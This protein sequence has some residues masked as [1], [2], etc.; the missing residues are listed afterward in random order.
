MKKLV[1]YIENDEIICDI[2]DLG[3]IP[4]NYNEIKPYLKSA[5]KINHF[6]FDEV[7]QEYRNKILEIKLL[8]KTV[9]ELKHSRDMALF[10]QIELT[11]PPYY[12]KIENYNYKA[13]L[14]YFLR[15][16]RDFR[17]LHFNDFQ[18][19]G[20]S[21]FN[22]DTLKTYFPNNKIIINTKLDSLLH[23]I[24]IKHFNTATDIIENILYD[25]INFG[26]HTGHFQEFK[27]KVASFSWLYD[28]LH[29]PDYIY[30]KN[31]L[32]A[33]KLKADL[34]FVR[35]TGNGTASKKYM[36]HLV[37]LRKVSYNTYVIVS[38]FPLEKDKKL[39]NGDNKVSSLHSK[40]DS[41]Q[42]IYIKEGEKLPKQL[43][44]MER[45]KNAF[46]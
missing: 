42:A 31:A 10:K 20:Q 29:N 17:I 2:C 40:V 15:K 35:N 22:L 23:L 4:Y 38:Q 26:E 5:H 39:S 41:S 14:L 6:V 24:N 36:H 11:K 32:K 43:N 27:S 3:K 34:I 21:S 37:A 25:T 45:L 12:L 7:I 46:S 44:D 28:T 13:I 16:F 30:D 9:S 18:D 19:R 1:K 8:D 33:K